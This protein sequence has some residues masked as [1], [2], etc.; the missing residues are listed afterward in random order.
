MPCAI[1][2]SWAKLAENSWVEVSGHG[3]HDGSIFLTTQGGNIRF[4]IVAHSGSMCHDEVS[5]F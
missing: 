1:F 5:K 2:K 4:L 3:K